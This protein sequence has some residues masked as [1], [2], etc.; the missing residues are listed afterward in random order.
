MNRKL[1]IAMT[2][3]LVVGIVPMLSA[4]TRVYIR[5][6]FTYGYWHPRWYAGPPVVFATPVKGELKLKTSDE[7]ARVYVDGGYLGIARHLKKFELRVG[8][9]DI[10]LRDARG[11]VLYEEHV[12]I[13][14]G[15]T[16]ELDAMGVPS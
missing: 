5:P 4:A 3:C 16:T 1:I 13:V 15:R 10:Q 14:P 12:A 8:K 9:H 6:S 11:D 2:L 7:D